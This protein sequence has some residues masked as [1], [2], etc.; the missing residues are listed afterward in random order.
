MLLYLLLCIITDNHVKILYRFS[1]IKIQLPK[2]EVYSGSHAFD[3]R[4]NDTIY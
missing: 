2:F 1:V 3:V 4:H